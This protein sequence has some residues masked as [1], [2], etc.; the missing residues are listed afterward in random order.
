[1]LIAGIALITLGNKIHKSEL[2]IDELEHLNDLNKQEVK[3]LKH[4]VLLL[5][6]ERDKLQ[7]INNQLVEDKMILEHK[8]T[9]TKKELKVIKSKYNKLSSD[10]LKKIIEERVRQDFKDSLLQNGEDVVIKKPVIVWALQKDDSLQIY[11][12]VE[13]QML[14]IIKNRD[15]IIDNKNLIINNL[16]EENRLQDKM[17]THQ[18]DIIDN[19][20]LQKKEIIKKHKKEI[21]KHKIEKVLIGVGAV[22]IIL[23]L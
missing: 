5:S 17:I 7:K 2:I 22:A 6:E 8:L 19:N 13:N 4:G 9:D 10:T 1:L 23:L 14:E 12:N 3:I 11:K 20:E 16:I 18:E 15:S 21:R